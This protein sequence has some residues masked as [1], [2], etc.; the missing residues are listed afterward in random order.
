MTSTTNKNC[1]LLRSVGLMLLAVLLPCKILFAAPGSILFSD[2]FERSSI[3]SDWS[4]SNSQRAGIGTY[5][6]NSGTRSL[7]TRWGAVTVTSKTFDLSSVGGAE[8]SMWIRIGDDIT[9]NFSEYPDSAGEDLVIQYLN[10]SSTWVTLETFIGGNEPAGAIFNRTYTLPSD[11]LHSNFQIRIG[12]TGGSGNDYDYYHIDDVTLTETAAPTALSYPFCDDFESG[13]GNWEVTAT[14]GDA[15]IGSQTY[16]SAGN[17][18]YLRWG[19]VYVSSLAIDTSS[20]TSPYLSLW[21]RRGS[22]AFSEDP[23]NGE[24]LTIEYLNSSNVWTTLDTFAGNGTPGEIL[25]LGYALP[26][27]AIHSNFKI[28]FHMLNGS[29]ANFDYWHVD[30]VCVKPQPAAPTCKTFRDEFS[31][32][33][34]SRND[35]TANFSTNWIETGDNGNPANGTIEINNVGSVASPDYRLQLEGNGT[36]GATFGAPSIER[37]ADL[38]GYSTATLSFD[39]SESGTW[40]GNDTIDVMVSNNGGASWTN[41]H[42]FKNDQGSTPQPFSYDISSYISSNFRVAFVERANAASEIFYI[43][44]LQIE[45][46]STNSSPDHFRFEHDGSG[47]TCNPENIVVRACM[48]ATCS[49]EY[50]GPITATLSPTGWVGGDTQT[51]NSGS[52][53]QLWHTTAG[54]ASLGITSSVGAANPPQCYVAGVLQ[55]DCNLTF[56]DSGFIFDVP[57]HTAATT[58]TVQISAVR[59]DNTSQQCV[60]TFQNVTK[61]VDFWSSYANPSSGTLPVD[62]NGTS[63]ATAAPGTGVSLNFDTNGQATFD[64]S[65][66]DAG[67]MLLDASYT[68]S[69]SESGLVLTGQDS[70]ISKPAGFALSNITRISDGST[71][72]AASTAAGSAF[73]PAGEPFAVTIRALNALGNTTPNFG[74]ETPVEGV[75]LSNSSAIDTTGMAALTAPT[76]GVNPPVATPTWQAN[77]VYVLNQLVENAGSIYQASSAGTSGGTFGTGTVGWTNLGTLLDPANKI[78]NTTGA[79]NNGIA[80]GTYQWPEVGIIDVTARI[81]DSNYLGAGDVIGS[82]SGNIGRFYPASFSISHTQHPACN[83][84]AP[85]GDEFTYAGLTGGAK[86]GQPFTVDGTITAFNYLNSTT[87][88][89]AGSFA[90]LGSAN[91]TASANGGTGNLLS[92]TVDPLS[93]TL[94]VSNFTAASSYGFTAEGIPQTVY[95]TVSANDGEASGN[96]TDTTKSVEYRFGRLLLLDAYGPETSDLTESIVAQYY[97]AS[98]SYSDN[99][100]DN[101]TSFNPATDVTLSTWTSNLNAGETSVDAV[102][103]SSILANGIGQLIYTAPGADNYGTVDSTLDIPWLRTYDSGT[104]NYIPSTGTLT[105]GHY[106]GDDRF[107]FW[108]ESK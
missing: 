107:L 101:C 106:R 19:N 99:T 83:E 5:T 84:G 104:G 12:Q 81:L 36:G 8:L 22:D 58:Q 72:P 90:K 1:R 35:G 88:N 103:S 21:L 73:I 33:D 85:A 48:D 70:F 46:C 40:E 25:E 29:G 63:I 80:T 30:D 9:Y 96:E 64:L 20:A 38:S 16:N 102:N 105:F 43:D 87:Q 59:K 82:T 76:G 86:A 50:S 4:I 55:P 54:V 92:W 27:D 67:S 49:S 69:A 17:S 23:D 3:G 24:D 71:N 108:Q 98:G 97:D 37:E 41:I 75:K 57:N 44:N 26:A 28:R 39:Y 10:S 6:S 100:L 7:Y 79:F 42:T 11:A 56:S 66:P 15:G 93:F 52:T 2:D 34:Y 62:I 94:G 18:L 95:L 14:S 32:E 74:Q 89:Y 45:A 51:F 78:F 53:L 13:L 47:I 31:T 77:T 65:Y 61:T 68:G 91:V 60:P